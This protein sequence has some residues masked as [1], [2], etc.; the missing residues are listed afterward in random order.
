MPKRRKKQHQPLTEKPPVD[1]GAFSLPEENPMP[2]ENE[3]TT[4]EPKAPANKRTAQKRASVLYRVREG[5]FL[6]RK[7]GSGPFTF[8]QLRNMGYNPSYLSAL[9]I[10]QRVSEDS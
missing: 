1:Q 6:H 3:E 8:R 7:I 10:V 2:L 9:R 5:R 4:E